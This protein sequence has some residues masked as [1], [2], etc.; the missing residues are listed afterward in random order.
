M[1]AERPREAFEERLREIEAYLDFLQA[2][3][4]QTQSGPPKVG[5]SAGPIT[6]QQ[7]RIL[8]SSVYLQLYSLVEATISRCVD[9]V[10]FAAVEGSERK[11]GDLSYELRRE[12]VRVIARTHVDL[13][14]EHRLESALQL[15]DHLVASLPIS[16]FRVERGGGGNWDDYQIE[17]ISARLGFHLKVSEVA[18][19]GVKR[20]FR[21]DM[22]PLSLVKRLRN[23][24]AHGEI[25]FAE[26]GEGVSVAELR[27]LKEKT[28][29]YL[30]EVVTSF[31][32]SIDACEYLHPARRPAEV[33]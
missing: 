20:P 6:A 14:Y 8:Y 15:C 1:I 11:A 9:A 3:E 12:W 5:E 21:D 16:E 27:D 24:L 2:I 13:N 33:V 18:W 30:R 31:T 32:A 7:Q 23:R 26:C 25:S 29:I 22:G 19:S 10:T 17:A 28:A 4:E